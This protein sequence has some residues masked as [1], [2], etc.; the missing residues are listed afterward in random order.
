M[1]I[2][3]FSTDIKFTKNEWIKFIYILNIFQ[4]VSYN[5]IFNMLTKIK[6]YIKFYYKMII[7]K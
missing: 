4:N 5:K 1:N 2:Y 6:V 7:Y 3:F